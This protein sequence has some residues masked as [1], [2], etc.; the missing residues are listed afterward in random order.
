MKNTWSIL[1][2]Y[3]I[4]DLDAQ[5][6]FILE[7]ALPHIITMTKGLTQSEIIRTLNILSSSKA[8]FD[9]SKN[10]WGLK[11]GKLF[12]LKVDR[13]RQNVQNYVNNVIKKFN[14]INWSAIMNVIL[15]DIEDVRVCSISCARM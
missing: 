4:A 12:E 11:I 1:Y 6:E 3:S 14:E 7:T 13:K 8:E 10:I 9:K 2:D 5:V 15:S